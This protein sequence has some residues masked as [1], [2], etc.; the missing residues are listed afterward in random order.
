MTA[1]NGNFFGFVPV[2]DNI[3]VIHEIL[4]K[5]GFKSQVKIPKSVVLEENLDAVRQ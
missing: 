1:C 5:C 2:I 4:K 3:G